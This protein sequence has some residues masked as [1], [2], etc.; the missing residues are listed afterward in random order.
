MRWWW[1]S[2]ATQLSIDQLTHF[3]WQKFCAWWN[4]RWMHV[5]IFL[6]RFNDQRCSFLPTTIKILTE[7]FCWKTKPSIIIVIRTYLTLIMDRVLKRLILYEYC[8]LMYNV[9][10]KF[11]SLEAKSNVHYLS[12]RLPS[13]L[14]FVISRNIVQFNVSAINSPP[15]VE[16]TMAIATIKEFYCLAR[17]CYPLPAHLLFQCALVC[18]ILFIVS[19]MIFICKILNCLDSWTNYWLVSVA[20]LKG[21][22]VWS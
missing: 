16:A 11:L 19:F 17:S 18:F 2:F 6:G 10:S 14:T 22:R 20:F 8:V 12:S 5:E 9:L 15:V 21:L 4:L 3:S 13:Y 7:A 1:F